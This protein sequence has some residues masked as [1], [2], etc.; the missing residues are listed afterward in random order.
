MKISNHLGNFNL[1]ILNEMENIYL[2]AAGTGITPMCKLIQSIHQ[3]S[4]IE[5]KPT[6]C[7]FL[8]DNDLKLSILANQQI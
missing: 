7:G 2:L 3:L 4:K 1:N 8:N 5:K 6:R